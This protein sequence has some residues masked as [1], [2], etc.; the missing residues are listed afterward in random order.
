MKFSKVG[1][2]LSIFAR[3]FASFE[4]PLLIFKFRDLK[5]ILHE[6]SKTQY[7]VNAGDL[8]SM[9][10]VIHYGLSNCYK[11]FSKHAPT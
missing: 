8:D 9:K 6:L 11:S 5:G 4:A 1:V 7:V 10:M 3:S 2:K